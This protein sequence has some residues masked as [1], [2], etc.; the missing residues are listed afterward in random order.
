MWGLI[1]QKPWSTTESIPRPCHETLQANAPG[2]K[3]RESMGSL[4]RK[5]RTAG[6]GSWF[7]LVTDEWQHDIGGQFV[8]R[9]FGWVCV[10]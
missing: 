7:S 3:R 9:D 2:M 10:A 6:K 4:L 8:K 1:G 5:R